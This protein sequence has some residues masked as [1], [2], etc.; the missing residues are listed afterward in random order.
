MTIG[1]LH[2]GTSRS[3]LR[4][5]ST[6]RWL[7]VGGQLITILVVTG[8]VGVKLPMAP[9][10][11]GVCALALFNVY[12][13]WRATRPQEPPEAEIFLHLVVDIA[14]LTWQVGWSGGIE[15]P[16]SSLFL[17]PIALS[18]LAL[19]SAWIWLTAAASVAGFAVSAI[20]AHPL[21]HVHGAMGDTFNLHKAGMLVNFLISAAV[22]LVFF[23]RL[24]ALR[25]AREVELAA[26]RERFTRN[27]GI[28]A[29]GHARSLRC[30]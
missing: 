14:V 5:L 23:S 2:G 16:F 4:L 15:N 24:A 6:L 17:L 21:P 26:L 25:R 28:L 3:F 29:L 11:A 12:A 1:E 30:T 10:W 8:P 9:L 13:I 27:E 22:L 19:P 18:I 20:L 7:A